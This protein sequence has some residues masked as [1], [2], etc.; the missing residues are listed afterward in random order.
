MIEQPQL[1]I[2][3]G[4]NG[5]GKSTF[6]RDF[7]SQDAFIFD[8]DKERA[9]TEARFPDLPAESIDFALNQFYFDCVESA[10]RNKHDFVLE[11]NFRDSG[12]MDTVKRFQ[13]NGYAV[14][15][16]YLVLS[17]IS[18][19][20]DRVTKRV[21]NGG[22]FVDNESIRFNYNEG[23]KNLNYFAKRFDNL[24]II[25][26]SGNFLQLRSLL[27]VQERQLV[28]L[29]EDL[30]EWIEKEITSIV[31]RYKD[32]S[33]QQDNDEERDRPRGPRR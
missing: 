25:D 7:S 15:M 23:L 17:G 8:P 32:N 26:S 4:P 6:S 20:I 9:K 12:I 19:S 27:S 5:A 11:T 24:E 28:F 13:E 16:I 30:P 18:Q 3:A 14:N 1:L 33:R 21:S 31:F 10:L 22:H 29:S 2:I